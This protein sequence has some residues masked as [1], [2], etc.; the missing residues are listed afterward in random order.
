MPKT[1]SRCRQP[2]S[3]AP[4]R[5]TRTGRCGEQL[6]FRRTNMRWIIL[7][8]ATLVLATHAHAK[9]KIV[10][11]TPDYAD[12]ARQIGGDFVEVRSVMKGP[13]NV[14]NVLAKPTEMVA[15]NK[16]DLFV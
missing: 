2:G 12:L 13:E 5:R 9:L 3:S 4:T 10:T 1:S 8:C 15:L 11:T 6:L 16:A 7:C 14:H